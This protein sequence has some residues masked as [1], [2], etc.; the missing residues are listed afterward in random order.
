LET[1]PEARYPRPLWENRIPKDLEKHHQVKEKL[2]TNSLKYLERKPHQLYLVFMQVLYP[3]RIRIWRCWFLWR[4][5]NRRTRRKT[6][7]ARREPITNLTHLWH[8]AGIEPGGEVSALTT[9]TSMLFSS[10]V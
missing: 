5:A 8:R 6:L 3:G 1:V 9:G 10:H 4:E 7:G 2:A